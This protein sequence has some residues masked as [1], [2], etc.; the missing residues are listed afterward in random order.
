MA[1]G[2]RLHGGR[3]AI[4]I[5]IHAAIM[6]RSLPLGR[7]C[8]LL[9]LHAIVPFF[10]IVVIKGESNKGVFMEFFQEGIFR[11]GWI[12]C[13]LIIR[14]DWHAS[15]GIVEIRS[16]SIQC[17]MITLHLLSVSF[18]LRWWVPSFTRTN[19]SFDAPTIQCPP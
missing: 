1:C 5:A 13:S 11:F 4:S 17:W 7:D 9:L 16:S 19:W 15:K 18:V 3:F 8:W 12:S 14:F 6:V 10:T 2:W